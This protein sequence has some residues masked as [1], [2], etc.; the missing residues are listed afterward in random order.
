MSDQQKVDAL[1]RAR[2][3]LRQASD[4]LDD[5]VQL[6]VPQNITKGSTELLFNVS[7][8]PW[9]PKQGDHGPFELSDDYGNVDHQQLLAFMEKHAG[10]A[11]TSEGFY[12]WLFPDGKTIGRKPAKQIQRRR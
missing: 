12:Y 2:D 1:V 10:G 11:V 4:A 8:I 6:L 3:G 9:K 5:L 7:K